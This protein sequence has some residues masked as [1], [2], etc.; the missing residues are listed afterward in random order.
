MFFLAALVVLVARCFFE[1][2]NPLTF[3]AFPYAILYLA[4]LHSPL[5]RFGRYGDFSYG[6]FLY[7]FPVQQCIIAISGSGISM[8]LMILLSIALTFPF[9]VMSWKWIESKALK[10]KGL[11]R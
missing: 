9:A 2:I 8:G 6:L 3:I 7:G 10:Y 1:A 11:V 4:Q 5:N